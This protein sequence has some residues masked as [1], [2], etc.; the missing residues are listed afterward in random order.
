MIKPQD[1]QPGNSYACKYTDLTK[2]AALAI[3][4]K[5]DVEHQLLEVRDVDSG[6]T[7]TLSWDDVY[8]IDT[9]EW[10]HE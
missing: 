3:I 2:N 5:R 8:D 4:L 7:M 10:T 6:H 9:V 1:I